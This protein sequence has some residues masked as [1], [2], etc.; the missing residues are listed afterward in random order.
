M[1]W[2][3]RLGV[4]GEARWDFA[5]PWKTDNRTIRLEM[6]QAAVEGTVRPAR[7][8]GAALT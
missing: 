4:K 5:Q 1:G 6:D 3:D 2:N 8:F 7:L